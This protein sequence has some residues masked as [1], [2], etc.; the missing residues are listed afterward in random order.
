[1]ACTGCR[2]VL[3]LLAMVLICILLRDLPLTPSPVH[4][5]FTFPIAKPPDSSRRPCVWDVMLP[6]GS[7]LLGAVG[8]WGFSTLCVHQMVAPGE[9][10]VRAAGCCSCSLLLASVPCCLCLGVFWGRHRSLVHPL[11]MEL[12]C[13]CP[14]RAVAFRVVRHCH[15]MPGLDFCSAPHS[16]AAESRQ[17]VS[18]Q[19]GVL[20]LGSVSGVITSWCGSGAVLGS[21]PCLLFPSLGGCGWECP[22]RRG[23]ERLQVQA[24]RGRTA[25]CRGSGSCWSFSPRP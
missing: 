6:C 23:K 17:E 16:L 22:W 7:W 1:M 13:W 19:G 11:A 15:S 8:A 10:A 5:F 25:L 24:E 20:V 3:L 2:A 12:C 18:G 4:L 14:A 21:F 9:A